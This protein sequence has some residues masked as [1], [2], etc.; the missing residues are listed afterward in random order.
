MSSTRT[1]DLPRQLQEV[2]NLLT[3]N[4][5]KLNTLSEEKK[6]TLVLGM[7][8][9]S[10]NQLVR[11]LAKD[12]RPAKATLF[13]D[14]A[15]IPEADDRVLLECASFGAEGLSDAANVAASFMAE[16]AVKRVNGVSGVV[17]VIPHAHLSGDEGYDKFADLMVS[18][19]N[20]ID[21]EWTVQHALQFVVLSDA[22][23]SSQAH[24][25]EVFEQSL[26]NFIRST[27]DTLELV[28]TLR[29][30][31]QLDAK[32]WPLID[33]LKA[34]EASAKP[35]LYANL[36]NS[37]SRDLILQAIESLSKCSPS[38]I[39]FGAYHEPRADFEDS[40]TAALDQFTKTLNA[41]RK[42]N[43]PL[44]KSEQQNMRIMAEFFTRSP[45]IPFK[46][47]EAFL[48]AF[49]A[50][51]YASRGL[52]VFASAQ[53]AALPVVREAPACRL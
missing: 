43:E 52:G 23:A 19:N 24:V 30:H 51:A 1:L 14:I 33:F 6:M 41:K 31:S 42:I 35:V 13:S 48:S 11:F 46:K 44:T 32:K 25:T 27:E 45:V 12:A 28:Q 15:S 16:S 37:D 18:L 7:S 34:L 2:H 40:L 8:G 5:E 36:A 50:Q 53:Q 3:T 26:T 10:N 22:L 9:L 4:L 29:P 38:V 21:N 20:L 49:N 17:V 47:V 39:N